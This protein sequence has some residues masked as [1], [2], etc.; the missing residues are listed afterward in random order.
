M[1]E[2]FLFLQN[3]EG[4]FRETL[5]LL[6]VLSCSRLNTQD[7]PG[8]QQ[9]YCSSAGAVSMSC[10]SLAALMFF[11]SNL[12]NQIIECAWMCECVGLKHRPGAEKLKLEKKNTVEILILET[13]TKA[14]RKRWRAP[15]GLYGT[16]QCM[17]FLMWTPRG[18]CVC[19]AW[20]EPAL[21]GTR[22]RS[23]SSPCWEVFFTQLSFEEWK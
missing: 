20:W 11:S 5:A 14:G 23:P 10:R 4:I 16:L 6:G 3:R 19:V 17:L 7:W 2:S 8:A 18:V 21:A 9:S 22:P 12:S 1:I 13:M 15:K